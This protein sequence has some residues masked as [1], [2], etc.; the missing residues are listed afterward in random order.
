MGELIVWDRR[1]KSWPFL[2]MKVYFV[3][4]RAAGLIN[5][6]KSLFN[7]SWSLMM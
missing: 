1:L 2:F 6:L 3:E 5:W 4:G 7:S